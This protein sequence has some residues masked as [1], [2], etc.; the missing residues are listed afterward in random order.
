MGAVK[1]D[2]MEYLFCYFALSY[3]CKYLYPVKVVYKPYL[4][5]SLVYGTLKCH[6]L[7]NFILRNILDVWN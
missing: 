2:N 6:F 5:S 3:I 7:H 4:F 1:L